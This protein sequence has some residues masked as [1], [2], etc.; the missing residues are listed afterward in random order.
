MQPDA[1]RYLT[2]IAGCAITMLVAAGFLYRVE[3]VYARMTGTASRLLAHS[4]WL[5]S[6]S[7]ERRSRRRL[8]LLEIF[9]VVSAVVALVAL[10][11]WWAFLADS[12][13]PS[14]PTAPGTEHG[15]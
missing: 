2:V 5:R 1:T 15:A 14:G 9:M 11:G 12:T 3:A 6:V 8:T 4:G 7:D 13:N 10:V